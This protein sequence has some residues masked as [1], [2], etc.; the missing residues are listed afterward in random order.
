VDAPPLRR[1]RDF[2]L[3]QAGQLFSNLGTAS[4]SIAY[5][6]LVLSVTGSAADAG[7][8]AFARS[9]PA[10][11]FLIPS[12]VAADRFDR[13][14]LM[15]LADVV[16]VAAIGGLAAAVLLDEFGLWI[17]GAA[18]FIEGT[19]AA[20]FSVSQIGAV[21][22]VV[23]PAQL[24]S[25]A[26]AQTGRQ[27]AVDLGGPPLGG[28]LFAIGRAVPFLF[29]VASY[30]LSMASLIA[31]PK[32]F[33]ARR[34]TEPSSIRSRVAEGFRFLWAQPFLRTTAFLFGLGN[35]IGPGL[36][37]SVVIIGRSHGLGSTEIGALTAVF[38]AC[39][40]V[41]S[42]LSGPVRRALA[43]RVVILLE[44]WTAT[45]IVAFLVW[46]NIYVLVATM[47][48]T[49]LVIPSTNSLVHGYRI[50][51]TPDHLLG[52]AESVRSTISLAIAPLGPLVAGLM[53]TATSPRIT[54]A[55]FSAVA[56]ALAIWGTAS[57]AIRDVPR[58]ED[59]EASSPR[60]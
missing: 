40:L 25:A 52:R 54:I 56:F 2:L 18:A 13:K 22:A 41:G 34:V 5:P 15:I 55:L 20:L 27:A 60:E 58:F 3:L 59:V 43:P 8:V 7:L 4:T 32:P 49:A 45:A 1:N 11:L 53:L 33:Q 46:P 57:S 29:D 24:P 44:L 36:F 42:L 10:A 38:G 12:G 51:I 28:A 48:P 21:R 23:P 14:R 31:I 9:L 47:L 30:A 19:A 17:V 16:R 37:L 39:I 26:A 35:F 6:L 50:A